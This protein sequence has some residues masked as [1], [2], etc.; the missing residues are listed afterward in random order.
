MSQNDYLEDL[1]DHQ[2][3]L[4]ELVSRFGEANVNKQFHEELSPPGWHLGHCVFTESFWIREVILQQD[5]LDTALSQLYIPELSVKEQRSAALPA[6]DE[7][8]DWAEAYQDENLQ[9]LA[10]LIDDKHPHELL[11]DH[12]L[13]F[14]LCQ[15][16]AQH[17]ETVCYVLAQAARHAQEEFVVSQSLQAQPLSCDFVTLPGGPA[18]IGESD[19]R[20][21]YDNEC[22]RLGVDLEQFEIAQRPVSS[23]EFLTFINDGGYRNRDLWGEAAWNWK[24]ANHVELP[25]GWQRDKNGNVFAVDINGAG[26]I[27]GTAA[28][29]GISY[30]EAQAFARWADARLPHEYE[31]EMAKRSH[32]L[33]DVGQVWEWCDNELHP[34]PGFV[35]FPYDGYSLPWFDGRHYTLR[36]HS[37]YTQQIVIR[38]SFRN[39]YQ[40]DKR[41]FPAGLRLAM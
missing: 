17:I 3:R 19:V 24:Q 5:P 21:H 1:K 27:D 7:L 33:N 36:G 34:Y 32:A 8:Y 16:Y 25:Q 15:H 37:Q 10:Q 35:A 39:F 41:H 4:V 9:L 28:V 20:R 22:A 11:Q 38:D 18:A 29:A 31:W 13:P 23:A 30:Y 26:E 14:F 6:A 2:S 12:Y 40:A